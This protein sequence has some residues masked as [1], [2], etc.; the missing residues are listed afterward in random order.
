MYPMYVYMYEPYLFTSPPESFDYG[1]GEPDREWWF[2]PGVG[3][4]DGVAGARRAHLEVVWR[5]SGSVCLLLLC[6]KCW[7]WMMNDKLRG[8]DVTG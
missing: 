4:G 7:W 5:V 2:G 1:P 8:M 3:P 6:R